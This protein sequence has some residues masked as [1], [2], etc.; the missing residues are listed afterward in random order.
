MIFL[1]KI[2]PVLERELEKPEILVITGMRQVGKTTLLSWLF[3]KVASSNKVMLDLENP[4][5][6]KIFEE[7]NYDN[8]WF[9]L[10]DFGITNKEKAFIFLDEVQNLPDVTRV[11]KYLYDHWN[12]KFVLS[13]SSSYYLK[14]LFPESLAG[15]KLVYE[16][17]PLDFGEF[18]RFKGVKRKE[19]KAFREMVKN[20]S[21]V[22]HQRL[23]KWY[24]EYM[25]FGGFPRVVLEEDKERKKLLLEEIFKSY[26]E[27]DVKSLADFKN[28]SRLR[29]L[30]LLVANRV[31]SRLD[32]GKLSAELGISRET[33]VSYLDFLEQTY[34]I[35][36]VP[37]YSQSVDRQV[38]GRKKVY[39]A[40]SGLANFLGRLSEGELFEQSVY[41]SLRG[42]YKQINYWSDRGNEVDFVLDRRV[43]LEVKITAT[44]KH[45]KRLERLCKK[46]GINECY[47]V[48]KNF[49]ELDKVVP[50]VYL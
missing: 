15:R 42:S 48:A 1:R 10:S 36:R 6:R 18:L 7:E 20:R 39:L 28:L 3:D 40:D 19:F 13:G 26:F 23:I 25:E 47:V 37:K 11:I 34:F 22:L 21:L 41:Q 32:I 45:V 5:H 8:V 31:G 35:S 14:N 44:N 38:A 4:L 46:I 43:G 49:S 12:V 27:I 9:N 30:I 16:L 2:Y 24:Q 33:V 29:D 50:V 17:Y